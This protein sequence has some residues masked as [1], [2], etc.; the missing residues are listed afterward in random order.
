MNL[1][2]VDKP[3]FDEI[4][5]PD[6]L[7]YPREVRKHGMPARYV[8]SRDR[9]K[10][11]LHSNAR[12]NVDQ[13]F[14]QVAKDAKK[15]RVLEVDGELPE[16]KDVVPSPFEEVDKMLPDR[17][18]SADKRIVHDQRTVNQATSK[19]WHPPALQPLHS[20]V[21][22]RIIWAKHRAPGLPVLMAKK[23]I[24]GAFSLL[25]VS[26][27]DVALFAG[28]LPW[29]PGKAFGDQEATVENPSEGD[30]T[31]I[32][33][34]SSFGF[35]GSPGENGACG[36]EQRRSITE[37]MHRPRDRRRDMSDGFDAKV[38]VDDCI[39]IEPWVG[40]RPWI[41]AEVFEDRVV[42]LLGDQAVNKEKDE[43][44]H[45]AD[46]V[47]S[48]YYGDPLRESCA[49]REEDSEGSGPFGCVGL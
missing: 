13:V 17:T 36:E 2:G 35:S 19:Y 4:L 5:H 22:R 43:V 11:K 20:Q 15:H 30:L 12:R 38:L 23:D 48:D 40:L 46:G 1:T 41:S 33:L 14:K 42:Q 26:P 21:A 27:A 44:P 32:Y 34:V 7:L 37:L 49:A 28:D 29:Q 31:V 25:W 6:H 10:A 18:I 39:L 8:G 47:G 3:E 45:Y 24:A 16:L 9:V